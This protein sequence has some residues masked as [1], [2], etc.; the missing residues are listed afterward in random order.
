MQGS[1]AWLYSPAAEQ[2]WFLPT[3]AHKDVYLQPVQQRQVQPSSG[4]LTILLPVGP[5]QQTLELLRNQLRTF[6]QHV[7][8]STIAEFLVVTPA[9]HKAEVTAFFRKEMLR[10]LPDS[11]RDL[12]RIVDDG[13]CI[14][15]AN[16]TFE[17]YRDPASYTWNGWLTQQLLKLACAPLVKTPFYMLLDADVF[18]ARSFA[19]SDLFELRP[20]SPDSTV[21][22][23]LGQQQPQ[24]Q[25]QLR[26]KNDCHQPYDGSNRQ[27]VEW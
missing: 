9:E 25:Q 6:G 4:L 20:C 24:Q 23:A 27:N 15:E 26:A 16:P 3:V 11:R 2:P 10:E 19:A 14:P 7:N 12:F 22:S 1:Q 17:W 18:A 5:D 21:C 8:L 13:E